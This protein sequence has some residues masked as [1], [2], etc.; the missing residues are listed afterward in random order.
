[1]LSAGLPFGLA[2]YE[3]YEHVTPVYILKALDLYVVVVTGTLL[4][5]L[6][7]PLTLTKAHLPLTHP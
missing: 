4:Y 7:P 5:P 1:M 3:G 6:P 2:C